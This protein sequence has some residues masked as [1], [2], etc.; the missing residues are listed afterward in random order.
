MEQHLRGEY[1]ASASG[2][3]LYSF[4]NAMQSAGICCRGQRCLGDVYQFQ[5]YAK[6]RSAIA[7]LAQIYGVHLELTPRRTLRQYLHR[8]RFRFGIPVGLLLAAGLLFYGSNIV[9]EIEVTG[10][11]MASVSEITTILEE[12]GVSRGSWIP[13]I[14]FAQC[15]HTLRAT[16]NELAWVGVRHT[17]NRLVVE[18]MERKSIPEMQQ[19]RTPSN[20]IAAQ[21]G[22]IVSVS[23]Y[24]GQ[25]MR[26]VGDP[27]QKGDLLVSGV[28]TD[29]TGHLGIRH[30]MGSIIGQYELT[31]KFTCA[32][33]QQL[34]NPTGEIT[35]RRYLD[36]FAWHIPLGKTE[37]PYTDSIK[38]SGYSWFSL[39]GTDLP[40][41]IYRETFHEY[42]TRTLTL[43]PEEANQNL[44]EQV[45]RYED[46]FLNQVEILNKKTTVLE[47]E[48]G[49][50]WTVTYQLQGEIGVQQ[51][52]FLQD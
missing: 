6:H 31:E 44:R 46:N 26:L 10:N 11:E 27:V 42:R 21:D 40:V 41:G 24:R 4:L 35:T 47:A 9:M 7:S 20:I 13:S 25:L 23:I 43:T 8:Y 3:K 22:Q 1:R 32:Y 33:E 51:E 5:F 39:L 17:G 38:T 15:E 29:E 28:V 30:A 19:T 16:V 14:D 49:I 50:E 34:R 45:Q 37:N 36:L 52:L 18:V 12:C 48:D 2:G